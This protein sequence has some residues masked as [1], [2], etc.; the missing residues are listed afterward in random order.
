M[1]NILEL[2][3]D[4]KYRQLLKDLRFDYIDMKDGA[5][6]K[7]HYSGNF[8]ANYTPNQVKMIRLAQ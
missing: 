2:P 5:K 4:K 3:L 6:I 1:K 7:H 8:V